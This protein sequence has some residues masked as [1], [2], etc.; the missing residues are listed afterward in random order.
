[1][2]T[3]AHQRRDLPERLMAAFD[4]LAKAPPPIPDWPR[5]VRLG[6]DYP[7]QVT[8]GTIETDGDADAHA[9]ACYVL[10]NLQKRDPKGDPPASCAAYARAENAGLDHVR[11]FILLLAIRDGTDEWRARGRPNAPA[12][13]DATLR[14]LQRAARGERV[15]DTAKLALVLDAADQLS[16]RLFPLSALAD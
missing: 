5:S 7:L 4:R 11:A 13:P 9:Y 1:M 3:Q 15:A 8:A 6:V 12:L 10:G 14:I 2:R 16:A